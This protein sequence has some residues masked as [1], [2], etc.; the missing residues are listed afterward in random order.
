MSISKQD[1]KKLKEGL[2]HGDIDKI[3]KET[4]YDRSYVSTFLSGNVEVNKDNEAILRATMKRIREN[5]QRK[6]ELQKQIKK[7]LE[8]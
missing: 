5:R 2:E 4:S 7:T 6:E 8:S 3:A 1:L